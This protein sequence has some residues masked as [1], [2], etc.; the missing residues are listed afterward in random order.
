[1][2][3]EGWG[4]LMWQAPKLEMRMPLGLVKH[5][6]KAGQNQNLTSRIKKSKHDSGDLGGFAG[7]VTMG[8]KHHPMCIPANSSKTMIGKVPKVDQRSTYLVEKTEDSNL[9]I[10]VGI[11]NTLV[12]PSKIQT[13]FGHIN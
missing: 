2:A 12:T 8:D 6:G 1:M 5:K 4:Q 10:G 3:K 9:P 7:R 11:N 13:S